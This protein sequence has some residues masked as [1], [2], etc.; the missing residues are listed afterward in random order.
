MPLNRTT[1]T[2][3]RSCVHPSPTP[4]WSSSARPWTSIP[5]CG[6]APLPDDPRARLYRQRR[7]VAAR[8]GAI[9]STGARTVPAL[10]YF[11]C[12]TSASRLGP[13]RPGRGRPR[14]PHT[15]VLRDRPVLLAG[16]VPGVLLRSDHGELPARPCP[17]F[18][19]LVRPAPRDSL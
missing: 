13:L 7:A 5:V 18:S 15:V 10:A 17:C 11:P 4:T 16:A 2:E 8:R 12:R 9:A 19:G 3:P 14:Q 6:H 1:S